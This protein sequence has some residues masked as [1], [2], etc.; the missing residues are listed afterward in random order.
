MTISS[1]ETDLPPPTS[2]VAQF[3]V[4]LEHLDEE[5]LRIVGLL[6]IVNAVFGKAVDNISAAGLE[7]AILS[8]FGLSAIIWIG[9]YAGAKLLLACGPRRSESVD[10]AIIGISAVACLIPWG[11]AAWVALTV[12]GVRMVAVSDPGTT[13]RRAAWFLV[14]IAFSVIWS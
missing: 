7:A 6:C 9:L 1:C 8:T 4:I 12:I 3:A 2:L 11:V 14:A 13:T 5:P 10:T